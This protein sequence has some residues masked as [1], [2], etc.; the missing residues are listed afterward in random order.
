MAW[1]HCFR[2]R[3]YN[4]VGHFVQQMYNKEGVKTD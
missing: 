4:N 3:E 1:S 2:P